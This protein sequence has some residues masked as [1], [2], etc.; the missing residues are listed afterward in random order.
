MTGYVLNRLGIHIS[1][2]GYRYIHYGLTLVQA[3]VT[4]LYSVTGL[5]YPAIAARYGVSP[6]S[7]EYAM[8]YCLDR[9]WQSGNRAFLD[10]IAGYPLQYRPYTKDFLAMLVE[11]LRRIGQDATTPHPSE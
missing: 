2:R 5:L 8:R 3:D 7:V 1:C 10:E 9:C 11:Y 4:L 6:A